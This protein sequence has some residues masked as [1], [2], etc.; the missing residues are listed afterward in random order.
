MDNND[1]LF[2]PHCHKEM[3]TLTGLNVHIKYYCYMALQKA[4]TIYMNTF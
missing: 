3:H 2:C 4:V 1:V